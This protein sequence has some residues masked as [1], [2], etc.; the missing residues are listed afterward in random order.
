MPNEYLNRIKPY[1]DNIAPLK[2]ISTGVKPKFKLDKT[3]KSV[4]FDIYGTLIISASGDLDKSN[5]TFE[6]IS[7]AI[8]EAGFDWV[9]KPFHSDAKLLLDLFHVTV[10]KH[11]NILNKKGHPYPE[12]D[13]IAVWQECTS[14]AIKKKLL[15]A[16][17]NINLHTL[18][19]VFELLSNAVYPMPNMNSVLQK[20]IS[21]SIPIGIVSNAQFYTPLIMNYFIHNKLTNIEHIEGFESDISVYSYKILRSKP[22]TFLFESLAESLKINYG[23][24]PN[25][26]LFVGNDMLKDVWTASQ[27]GFKTALFAAD[28]RSLKMREDDD[29]VKM[30]KADYVITNLKQLFNILLEN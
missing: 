13:I 26:V 11:Q 19:V 14:I 8:T 1:L 10:L 7:K 5:I 15:K 29:R 27:L 30:V 9:N 22:D 28:E 21:S 25:E 16:K 23:L 2:T 3:I 24:K 6:G 17:G 18:T 12:V 20:L 4:V